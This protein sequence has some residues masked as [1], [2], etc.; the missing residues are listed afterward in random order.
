LPKAEWY[1]DANGI[2]ISH[3]HLDHLGALSNIPMEVKV[4]LPS[5]AIYDDMEKRWGQSPTWFSLIPRKYYVEIEE[6]RHFE[7]DKNDVMAIPV[8]HSAYPSYSLIYFGRKETILYTGDFRIESFLTQEE[9]LKVM[10]G[11]S[12]FAY[13]Q[14]NPDIKIDTL[15]VEGTNLGSSRVPMTPKDTI[16]ITKRLIS[17]H[18]PVI[19]TLHG[20][21]L[22]YTYALMKLAM[23]FNLNCYVASTQIA[24]LLEKKLQL[25]LKTKLIEG[26]ADH[27][28][29]L[30]K[31]TLEEVEEES[32]ILISYREVIDF[33]KQLNLSKSYIGEPIAIVSEP[34]PEREEASEYNVIANWFS[35]MGI[36]HYRIRTSGHYYPYEL[37]QIFLTIKPKK[38]L[39]IHTINPEII[40]TT[41]D[42]YKF[43]LKKR[44]K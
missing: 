12:L 44:F 15:I 4:Y 10:G 26:Y 5:L 3:M 27:P 36:Q 24:K 40:L 1:Q 25:P 30:E 32:L 21:D 2:Y 37:K 9:S 43:K 39:P 19:T 31:V 23:E 13:L 29:L 7:A 16:E 8:S 41:A 22:E 17:N 6:L 42:K 11:D 28:S 38:I 20:L 35:K 18:K 34:E 14:E 33:L